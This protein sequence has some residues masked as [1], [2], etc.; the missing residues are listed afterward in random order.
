M[1]RAATAED[2]Y[3]GRVT[4]DIEIQTLRR[5]LGIKQTI[6]ERRAKTLARVRK[7]RAAKKA[8]QRQDQS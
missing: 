5:L 1:W 7:H 8:A 6:E 4:L 3:M 2:D